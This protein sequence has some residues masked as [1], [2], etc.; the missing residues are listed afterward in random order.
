MAD[1]FFYVDGKGDFNDNDENSINELLFDMYEDVLEDYNFP[2]KECLYNF[3]PTE[4]YVVPGSNECQIVSYQ[5]L[6]DLSDMTKKIVAAWKMLNEDS[7]SELNDIDGKMFSF[8]GDLNLY[9]FDEENRMLLIR[10]YSVQSLLKRLGGI[11]QLFLLDAKISE[12]VSF[13]N[14]NILRFFRICFPLMPYTALRIILVYLIQQGGLK[15]MCSLTE[16]CDEEARHIAKLYSA[17]AKIYIGLKEL[18]FDAAESNA[19]VEVF[20][21]CFRRF[22]EMFSEYSSYMQL[23]VYVN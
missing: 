15:N 18:M 22:E 12:V 23:Q 2:G 3:K 13:L 9:Q 8:K 4:F 5:D 6:L 10:A 14:N 7:A 17:L 21:L 19:D 1:D 11:D 20:Q 16:N